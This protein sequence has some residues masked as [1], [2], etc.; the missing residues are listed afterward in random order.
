[1]NKIL[2]GIVRHIVTAIGGGFVVEGSLSSNDL[3]LAIGAIMTLIGVVSSVL[4][5]RK[6]AAADANRITPR[7]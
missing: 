4:S 5:K 1:M 6:D 7:A 3:D 2:V